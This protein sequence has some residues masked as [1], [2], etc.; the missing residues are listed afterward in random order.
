MAFELTYRVNLLQ[1]IEQPLILAVDVV[2]VLSGGELKVHGM[3][4]FVLGHAFLI[5]GDA[6][7]RRRGGEPAPR[8]P[9][10]LPDF[11]QAALMLVLRAIKR[12]E[13]EI[14]GCN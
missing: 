9:V 11:L 3:V 10:C 12:H 14:L 13:G 5:E 2:R 4:L 8:R 1:P 6:T 7:A